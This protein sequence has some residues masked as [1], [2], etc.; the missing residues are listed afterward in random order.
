[1]S[2]RKSQSAFSPYLDGALSGREMRALE[3]HL[4]ACPRCSR[5]FL[6]LQQAQRRVAGLGRRPAPPELELR[7]RLAI[8]REA[9]SSPRHRLEAVFARL[10]DALSAFMVPATAGLLS[11][12]VFFGLLMGFFALPDS[13]RSSDGSTVSSFYT[14]PELTASPFTAGLSNNGSFVIEAVIGPDGR[15]QDFRIISAPEREAPGTLPQ[16]KNALIFSTFR[17][18]TAFGRPT[19]GRV[20]LSFANISVRG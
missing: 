7:L 20:V 15:V 4:G 16:L 3:D 10:E 17:P 19:T 5:H 6:S 11:A 2:C 8:S 12:V 9:A 14:P 1:M 13:F 18:A